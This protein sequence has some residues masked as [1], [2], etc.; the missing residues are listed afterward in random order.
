MEKLLTTKDFSMK[1]HVFAY[2]KT[3]VNKSLMTRTQE[4]DP[5]VTKSYLERTNYNFY[6]ALQAYHKDKNSY[7]DQQKKIRMFL[8]KLHPTLKDKSMAEG[9]LQASNWKLDDAFR[10]YC[11]DHGYKRLTFI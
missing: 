5:A 3:A 8:A 7:E 6:E 2:E 4:S 11:K 10:H 1:D 9:Y